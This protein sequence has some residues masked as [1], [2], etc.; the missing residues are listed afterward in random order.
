MRWGVIV[1]HLKNKK[2]QSLIFIVEPPFK[3]RM[4]RFLQPY[5]D[6]LSMRMPIRKIKLLLK[7]RFSQIIHKHQYINVYLY[8]HT[9]VHVYIHNC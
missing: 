3:E 7:Q 9:C 4:P 6:I 5:C 2:Y 8:V 1:E